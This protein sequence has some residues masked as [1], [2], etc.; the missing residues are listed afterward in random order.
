MKY[1]TEVTRFTE[2]EWRKIVQPALTATLR[3]A[4]MQA[5]FHRAILHRPALYQ[6]FGWKHPFY[7]QRIK[8]LLVIIQESVN[9]DSQTDMLLRATAKLFQVDLGIDLDLSTT[10]SEFFL[11]YA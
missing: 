1:S 9:P 4:K 3:K 7:L 2:E 10:N 6:K 11:Q 8:H 5:K